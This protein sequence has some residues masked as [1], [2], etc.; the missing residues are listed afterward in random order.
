VELSI[1]FVEAI[2]EGS[3]VVS[4]P[5]YQSF[6]YASLTLFKTLFLVKC[7]DF[8]GIREAVS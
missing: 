2:G 8:T 3:R 1:T 7:C 4:P 5:Y 6:I